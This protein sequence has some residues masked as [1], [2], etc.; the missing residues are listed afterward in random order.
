MKQIKDTGGR[1]Q[2]RKLQRA[3]SQE[4]RVKSIA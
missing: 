3:E 4:Q 2:D 1:M